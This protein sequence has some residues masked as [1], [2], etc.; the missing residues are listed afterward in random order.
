MRGIVPSGLLYFIIHFPVIILMVDFM[1]SQD[2]TKDVLVL[3][4]DKV[5][6]VEGSREFLQA[7][8]FTSIMLPVEGQGK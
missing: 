5:R 4:Q 1:A 7:L 3:F 6:C 2:V 8:G